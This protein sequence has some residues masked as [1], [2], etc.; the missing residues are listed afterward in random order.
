MSVRVMAAVWDRSTHSGNALLMLLAIADFADDE[1][2]SYPSVSTLATKC[3]LQLRGA[4]RLLA[5]LRASGELRIELN[6]GPKGCNRYTVTPPKPLHDD[7]PLHGGAPLHHDA[8]MHQDAPLHDDARGDAP[9]CA[10]P[11]HGGAPE[12]SLNHQEPPSIARSPSRPKRKVQ[13]EHPLFAEFYGAYP[14][15][16][17]R[18]AALKAFAELNPDAPTLKAMLAA[19]VSQ[20]LADRCSAGE[21][22]FVSHPA[23]WLNGRRWEDQPSAPVGAA[24]SRPSS[25]R[26]V[27]DADE[28]F[29]VMR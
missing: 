12:P 4:Q 29:E 23:N 25:R 1:G 18:P 24:G 13:S 2:R 20:G 16:V 8:P 28:T 17:N 14:L 21:A 26:P 22:R 9:P 5:E 10:I 15:K 7:A 19:I 11:L 6:A 3:R 27:L